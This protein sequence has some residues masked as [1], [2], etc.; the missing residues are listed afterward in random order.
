M[1]PWPD[2]LSYWATIVHILRMNRKYA[3]TIADIYALAN[4]ARMRLPSS[5]IDK[6][7]EV[8]FRVENMPNAV[9]LAEMKIEDAF[10]LTSVYEGIPLINKSSATKPDTPDII[11]LFRR[12]ILDEWASLGDVGLAELLAHIVVHQFSHHFGWS[13]RDVDEIVEW[14]AE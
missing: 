9:L 3:P 12:P 1:S 6:A 4:D 10:D 2:P 8:E 7:L 13:R 11:W 5:F 14:W